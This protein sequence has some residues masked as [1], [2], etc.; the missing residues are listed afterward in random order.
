[1]KTKNK[2]KKCAT[3][4]ELDMNSLIVPALSLLPG[5][6]QFA[7]MLQGLMGNNTPQQDLMNNGKPLMGNVTSP[8]MGNYNYGGPMDPP[9]SVPRL[10]PQY[11]MNQMILPQQVQPFRVE[12][13]QIQP[14]FRGAS[15]YNTAPGTTY[16][17]SSNPNYDNVTGYGTSN[18]AKS[19]DR[20]REKEYGGQIDTQLSN[21][22]FQVKGAPNVTDGNYYPELN[23]KLDHNEVV[24]DNFVYS[25]AI[26]NITTGN[27]FAQDA[28]KY[29]KST[30]KAERISSIYGD[31]EAAATI[32]WNNKQMEDLKQFQELAA[33]AM[34]LRGET[35]NRQYGGYVGMEKGGP[36]PWE[37]FDVTEFQNWA[38]V[39]GYKLNPDGKWGPQ[40]E[41]VF[42]DKGSKYAIE[43]G[44]S[45]T[46][47]QGAKG[48]ETKYMP[49]RSYTTP[50]DPTTLNR[51]V[52]APLNS[53]GNT[54]LVPNQVG[55]NGNP[56]D[57]ST[58]AP[59][60]MNASWYDRVNNPVDPNSLI[61]ES[62]RGGKVGA[63]SP[64]QETT[65]APAAYR[66]PFTA[67]DAL[68]GIEVASKFA[69][70]VGGY[71]KENVNL[72]N[73][74]I[75]KNSYDVAPQLYQSQRN[76][77][78][79]LN[80]LDTSNIN[81][82]R[83]LYN[84]TYADKLNADSN[85]LAKYQDMNNQAQTQYEARLSDRRRYNVGQQNYTNDLNA[86]NKGQYNTLMDNAFTSLGNFGE[87]LN[88][89]VYANDTMNI[90][91]ELY[92]K[93]AGRVT[94]ALNGEDILKF[95][96]LRS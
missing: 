34:G 73:T 27:T 24:K 58:M 28:A 43:K 77:R 18:K 90:Y 4:G 3:G 80:S 92:P 75:T 93:V 79:N 52:L 85:T 36:L 31:K 2:T 69:G 16:L 35:A 7:P 56:I 96:K 68:Q 87:G 38:V 9:N 17:Q 32:K 37:S 54:K 41:K 82:R 29:E 49:V 72:D 11:L 53:L 76:M 59:G 21:N 25:N 48:V 62:M 51:E 63:A 67:G 42:N 33:T 22:S 40:T 95:L 84:Q 10:A 65:S 26:K 44:Y 71:D 81:L 45:P 19:M 61:P 30:G 1:M 47:V 50:Q 91:N 13:Q 66:T 86:R 12:S 6:G 15:T 8:G 55:Q 39:N 60:S 46:S 70:L 78:N 74:N 64:P 23:V 83:S 88:Q 20:F 89:K 14:M 57:Y 94:N 5:V